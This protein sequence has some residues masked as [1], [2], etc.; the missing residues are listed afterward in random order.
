MVSRTW[1]SGL[2]VPELEALVLVGFPFRILWNPKPYTD[3]PKSPKP[4]ALQTLIT[5]I[6]TRS[7]P[8]KEDMPSM[9]PGRPGE[10]PM[11]PASPQSLE[12]MCALRSLS[13]I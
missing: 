1:A 9:H 4:E 11:R 8:L 12:P 3:H 6:L 2:R 13:P 7:G 10:Y 5:L